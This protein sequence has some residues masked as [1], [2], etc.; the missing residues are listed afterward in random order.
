M[1]RILIFLSLV[2]TALLILVQCTSSIPMVIQLWWVS[3][4]E[5]MKQVF[6]APVRFW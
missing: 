2:V 4:S 3:D 5:L 6:T 1:R